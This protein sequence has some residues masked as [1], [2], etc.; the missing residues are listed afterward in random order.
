MTYVLEGLDC[1]HCAA[2][3]ESEIR[4]IGGLSDVSVNFATKTVKFDPEYENQVT[5]ILHRVDPGVTLIYGKGISQKDIIDTKRNEMRAMLINILMSSVLLVIGV[6]ASKSLHGHYEIFEYAIYVAAYLFAGRHVVSDAIRNIGR[7]RV[8]DENFLMTVATLG[9]FAIHELPEAVGVMLFFAVGEYFQALAVERSRR[10][11]SSLMDIRPDTAYLKTNRGLQEVSPETVKVGDVIV[12]R[13]GEKVPLDG[14]VITGNSFLDTSSLTGESIPKR[15]EPGD[16]ALAGTI[17]T[18]GL[19]EISVEKV[20]GESSVSKILDLVQNAAGRKAKTEQF[21][22]KFARIYTPLVVFTAAGIAFLPPVIIPGAVFYDWLYRALTILV[23]SCPCALVVSIPLGYFGGI[24]GASRKGILVKGANYLDVLT[25]VD[26]IVF[27]KTGTLTKGVFKVTGII[28]ANGFSSEEVLEW[29]AVAESNSHHPVAKSIMAAH[30][31]DV[32]MSDVTDY[33]EIA[34]HGVK[35]RVKGKEVLAGNIKLMEASGI[36]PS[37]EETTGTLVHMAVGGIYAGLISISDEIKA[38]AAAAI[39]SLKDLGI[40]RTLMLTGDSKGTAGAVAKELGLDDFYAELLPEDKVEM[41]ENIKV[42]A[43]GKVAFVGDGINDA[44]VI[45]MADVG[46]A[47]GGLGS[48]AAIEAADVVIMEDM[49]SKISEAVKLSHH[50]RKIVMQNIVLA[51]G[52]KGVFLLMGAFGMTTM[53]E[54]VFADVGVAL[55]AILNSTRT[56]NHKISK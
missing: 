34:G 44:P 5:D 27:D 42:K 53:W 17:N 54:A 56:L 16:K 45:M 38:D 47:M 19:L 55:L 30:G 35:A 39:K 11:I 40:K 2:K 7:G 37:E 51:L 9:A 26:T 28:P 6:M 18:E 1:A 12:V 29:A 33:Q 49:P 15:V 23:I 36:V 10:S 3:I 14:T 31:K 22:T 52:V 24:G 32:N 8:F 21:I 43:Q 46:I 48:D 25:E 4:K 50:T 13:P 41:L 20:F